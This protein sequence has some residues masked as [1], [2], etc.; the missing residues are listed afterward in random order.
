MPNWISCLLNYTSELCSKIEDNRLLS[1]SK[2]LKS[3]KLYAALFM[4]Y[5]NDFK[6]T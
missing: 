6:I 5:K 3:L 4:K 2:N 1:S